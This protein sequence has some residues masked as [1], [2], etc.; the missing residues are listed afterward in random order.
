LQVANTLE[1]KAIGGTP[2]REGPLKELLTK[3]T[4]NPRHDLFEQLKKMTDVSLAFK[5]PNRFSEVKSLVEGEI[6]EAERDLELSTVLLGLFAFTD[7][8][9]IE[10]TLT[11]LRNQQTDLS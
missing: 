3:R 10:F 6:Y 2:Y 4:E 8:Q 1:S 7:R 9:A 11:L 5:R